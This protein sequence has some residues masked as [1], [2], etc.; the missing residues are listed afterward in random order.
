[1]HATSP[2]PGIG[3]A[4]DIVSTA[5]TSM[6]DP[7]TSA[8]GYLD[9]MGELDVLQ[10]CA[11]RGFLERVSSA[12]RAARQV[13]DG[14]IAAGLGENNGVRYGSQFIR[15]KSS[16]HFEVTNP[17]GLLEWLGDDLKNV[18]N[19]SSRGVVQIGRL[20][21]LA[22]IKGSEAQTVVDTFGEYRSDGACLSAVPIDK[23][24]KFAQKLAEGEMLYKKGPALDGPD[25][26]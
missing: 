12:A 18:I 19:I 20:K 7:A 15:A 22:E 23:A 10:L 21:K 8:D 13:V 4:L 1:M 26:A 9:E 24:P 14:K 17:D 3:T 2:D 25:P 6:D 16:S 5:S 11:L